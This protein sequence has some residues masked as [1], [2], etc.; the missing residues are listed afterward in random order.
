MVQGMIESAGDIDHRPR[1]GWCLQPLQCC[2]CRGD[3]VVLADVALHEFTGGEPAT[4]EEMRARY[5]I[6]VEGSGSPRRAVVQ[7]DR[8]P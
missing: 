4:V 7:L 1:H 6:W 8:A 3:V 5:A 2:R